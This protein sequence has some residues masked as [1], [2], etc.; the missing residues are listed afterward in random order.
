MQERRTPVCSS[1]GGVNSFILAGPEMCEQFFRVVRRQPALTANGLGRSRGFQPDEDP[2]E[3]GE[4]ED[5]GL[6]VSQGPRSDLGGGLASAAAS[7]D[8]EDDEEDEEEPEP[9]EAAAVARV[10]SFRGGGIQRMPSS[11][12]GVDHVFSGGIPKNHAFMLAASPGGGKSTLCR[13]L[14]AGMAESGLRVMIAAGEEVGDIAHEEFKRLKLYKRFPK[15]AKAVLYTGSDDT[16]AIIAAAKLAEVDVL[17][18][19]SLSILTSTRV[20]GAAGEKTQVNYA[21]YHLMQAAHAS[22][23]YEATRPLT[24][25]MISHVTKEGSMAGPNKAKHW[26]DGA[27]GLEHVHPSTLEASED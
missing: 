7:E 1:C 17:F 5:G 12:P 2:E 18:V 4:E 8:D 26:T 9:V 19:D 24:I 20:Q 6:H 13:Q 16:D 27:F 14:A 23:E 22:N 3:D 10:S 25:V 11:E 21:A 15:G